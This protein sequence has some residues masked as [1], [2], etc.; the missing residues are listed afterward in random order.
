MRG[1][2]VFLLLLLAMMTAAVCA[3]PPL[4]VVT[5]IKPLQLLALAVGGDAVEVSALLDAKFS[6]HDYQLR[7]SDRKRLDR[8][9]LIFWVGPQ[10]EVF[11]P[12]ALSALSSHTRIVALQNDQGDPHIWM[13]PLAMVGLSQR[14]AEVFAEARPAQAVYFRGNAQRLESELRREDQLLRQRLE[15]PARGYMVEHDSYARFEARYGLH[16]LAA[17]TNSGDVPASAAGIARITQ[18]LDSG[19][20]GCV[21]LEPYSSKLMRGL[22]KNH[23]A[24]RSVVLD[25]LAAQAP[26]TADGLVGFYRQLGESVRTCML[27]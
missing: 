23:T 13:D 22:L 6:P 10:L 26:L 9:E 11:L 21:W 14:V 2:R 1:M 4:R 3:E 17:L 15:A 5:S 24:A 27:P 8:A 12:A 16:H 7:P 19:A 20:I 25:A 18:L